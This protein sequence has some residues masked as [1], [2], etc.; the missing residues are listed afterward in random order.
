MTA[1]TTILTA[2]TEDGTEL[3]LC[4]CT[5]GQYRWFYDKFDAEVSAATIEAAIQAGRDLIGE[6]KIV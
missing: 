6:L 2:T 1:T 3:E 5:D 4:F